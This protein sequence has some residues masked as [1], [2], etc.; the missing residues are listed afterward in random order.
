MLYSLTTRVALMLALAV[1]GARPAGAADQTILGRQLVV[2]NPFGEADST[3]KRQFVVKAREIGSPDTIVGDPTAGGA[4]LSITLNGG[5]PS[6]QT[7]ALPA[8]RWSGN[9]VKGFKYRDA[10]GENGPVKVAELKKSGGG[11]FQIKA[12]AK[13]VGGPLGI[14]TVVP[15]NPGTDGCV[16]LEIGGGGDAYGVRFADGQVTNDGAKQFKVLNPVTEGTCRR[17]RHPATRLPSQ[18]VAE[19]A[20]QDRPATHYTS[21]A[22]WTCVYAQR[23]V[24]RAQTQ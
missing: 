12:A 10:K 6:M 4:S 19:L 11:V 20:Q 15:P 24:P 17:H 9:A 5:T 18:H 8:P 13:T 3:G 1:T 21:T 22:R 23:R 7:F 2:K 14:I 16:R